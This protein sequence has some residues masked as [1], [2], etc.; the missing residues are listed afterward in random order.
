MELVARGDG[1]LR[2]RLVAEGATRP[3]GQL[4]R[5]SLRAADEDIAALVARC[6]P[7]RR[8]SQAPASGSAGAASHVRPAARER[9]RRRARPPPVAPRAPASTR[10]PSRHRTPPSTTARA[11]RRSHGRLAREG[12]LDLSALRGTGPAGRIIKRDVEAGAAARHVPRAARRGRAPRSAAAGADFED[13]PLTQIRKTIARAARRIARPD[14]DVLP[15][16]RVRPD[17]RHRAPR[18]A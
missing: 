15:H 16:R 1:V 4:R 17:Q 9:R 10:A 6:R 11:R 2:K 5:R 13:V 3:G 7:P 12:G 14:P 18:G 8:A